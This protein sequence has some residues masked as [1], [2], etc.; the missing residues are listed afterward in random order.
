MGDSMKNWDNQSIYDAIRHDDIG[1]SDAAFEYFGVKFSYRRL[2]SEIERAAKAFRQAG[3]GRGDIVSLML[4]TLPETLFSIYALNR[5]GAVVNMID[6]RSTP[7]QLKKCLER[8]HSR[9]LLV[10]AF[11]IKTL[12]PVRKDI[13]VDKIIVLRGCDSMPSFVLFW[14]KLGEYF[15]GRRFITARSRKYCFWDKFIAS[16]SAFDGVI[17]NPRPSDEAAMIFQTS[18]TTGNPKSVVHASRSINKSADWIYR[19][20]RNNP[21]KGDRVLSILPAFAFFGFVS[22]VHM[23]LICGMTDIIIPLFDYHQFGKLIAR[24]K[25]NYTFGI[26]S[27]WEHVVNMGDAIGDLS[28]IKDVSVAGEI[29]EPSLKQRVNAFLKENGSPAE[30]TIAYGMTETG[31]CVSLL[32]SDTVENADSEKGNVG[33]PRSYVKVCI[34]DNDS[35]REVA[36]GESGEICLQTEL[37]MK[38]YF[39]DPQATKQLFR[40]HPDGQRW[41]HT[42]DLGHMSAEGILYVE[43]RIKRM[44]VR[45]DGTKLFPVEIEEAIKKHPQVKDCAVIAV[46]DANHIQAQAPFAFVVPSEGSL[47][48]GNLWHFIRQNLPVHMQPSGIKLIESIPLTGIGKPDYIALSRQF[49]NEK[50]K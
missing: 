27:H 36:C 12:E 39:Q 11:Y 13:D 14:Y 35:G 16:G 2:Y 19:V 22:N 32:N 6:I 20:L 43:G 15:N 1:P 45:Y 21:E 23:A 37:A 34:F 7:Q 47:N 44:I 18:G 25:P 30:M 9:V 46:N 40:S 49:K 31:G 28:F 10:M 24:H 17:D 33:R 48:I 50:A 8:T 4:P 42:G 26:P 38:E 29:V 3:V 41:L 5:I